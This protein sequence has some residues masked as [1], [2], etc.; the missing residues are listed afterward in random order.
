MSPGF[1]SFS[2]SNTRASGGLPPPSRTL[3][4]LIV[5]TTSPASMPASSA[6]PPGVTP[7]IVTPSL[8]PGASN[9]PN[10]TAA[11]DVGQGDLKRIGVLL[12]QLCE[13]ARRGVEL[14]ARRVDALLQVVRR[15][16][17]ERE[18]SDCPQRQQQSVLHPVFHHRVPSKLR[19]FVRHSASVRCGAAAR[20][21]S[22]SDCIR[23]TRCRQS[24]SAR[25]GSR[26]GSMLSGASSRSRSAMR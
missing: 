22:V 6:G 25:T 13:F 2:T 4:P 26:D 15:V 1:T 7:A 3:E 8:L 19:M 21:S 16:G 17:A 20:S 14:R 10:E 11:L 5:T 12:V 9:T 23:P 18:R 24:C